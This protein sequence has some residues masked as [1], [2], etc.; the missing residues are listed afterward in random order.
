V[1]AGRVAL[2]LGLGVWLVYVTTAGGSL[3]TTDA[4]SMFRA[5][6]ALVDRGRV[7]VPPESALPEWRGPDGRYYVPF[8]I[9]QTLYDVPFLVAGRRL[10]ALVPMPG[11]PDLLPKALV[12][13]ASTIPAAVAVAFGFLIAWRLSQD[14]LAAF[15]AA[16][17][18]AFGSA[19]WPYAVFG[20]NAALTAGALTAGIWGIAAGW[21]TRR[22]S[23]LA[24]GGAGLGLAILTRHEMM[25]AAFTCL[26]WVA[27]ESY[28]SRERP[29][30]TAVA[31]AGVLAAI[32]AWL[33]YNWIRFRDPFYSGHTPTFSIEGIAGLMWSP[34]G[35]LWL[36]SPAAIGVLALWHRL[37]GGDALSWLLLAII[38]VQLT[39]YALLEDWLGTRSYGP[40]YLVPLLPL[41]VAP[42]ALWWRD[43]DKRRVLAV[44]FVLS[45]IVQLPGVLVDYG[46]VIVESGAPSTV[47]RRFE[48]RWCPLWLNARAA[49]RAVPAN[50]RYVA[51]LEKPPAIRAAAAAPLPARLSFS[52]DFWW[53][54]LF[55]LGVLPRFVLPLVSM[56]P[57]VAAG[58][59]LRRAFRGARRLAAGP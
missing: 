37:R 11:A 21:E 23:L 30:W 16:L 13:M 57:L 26:L 47:E 24:A 17:V 52:L 44:V 36:Y 32:A 55:Y 27:F 43:L 7:D 42:V 50:L 14:A 54:Y 19:L 20:F 25:L 53:L 1:T 39:F 40:R 15:V 6:K 49:T 56:G 38:V 5:A 33:L 10:A 45:I 3:S 22:A 29:H 35:S 51:G 59:A 2:W 58:L 8:G 4:V 41:L 12:G 9:G 48:W 28:R 46:Q 31:S 18:L 34:A